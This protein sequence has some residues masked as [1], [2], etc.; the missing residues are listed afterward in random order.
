MKMRIDPLIRHCSHIQRGTSLGLAALALQGAQ[1]AGLEGDGRQRLR[2]GHLKDSA[3]LHF[4]DLMDEWGPVHPHGA[5]NLQLWQL[6]QQV[7]RAAL[8]T[9]EVQGLKEKILKPMGFLPLSFKGTE[10]PV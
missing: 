4:A 6:H 1:P 9:E 10:S 7:G 8:S 5:W 2:P 3:G